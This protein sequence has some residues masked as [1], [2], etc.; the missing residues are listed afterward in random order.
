MQNVS[1]TRIDHANLRKKNDID[2]HKYQKTCNKT[3]F[4]IHYPHNTS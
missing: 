3:K 1:P 2:T 4:S